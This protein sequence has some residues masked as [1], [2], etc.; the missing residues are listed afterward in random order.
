MRTPTKVEDNCGPNQDEPCLYASMQAKL[1]ATLGTYSFCRSDD[2]GRTTPICKMVEKNCEY[3]KTI[4][5]E[6]NLR[7][8]KSLLPFSS[9]ADE[10]LL[11]L[12]VTAQKENVVQAMTSGLKSPES[13]VKQWSSAN[14]PRFAGW[15]GHDKET[16]FKMDPEYISMGT[17]ESWQMSNAPVLNMA[18]HLASLKIFKSFKL[19]DDLISGPNI[20]FDGVI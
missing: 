6:A 2:D 7:L 1:L 8:K 19:I 18:I 17:A 14:L 13:I 12:T 16:R 11:Q 4:H 9:L 5:A 20:Y 10:N 15:W 3:S